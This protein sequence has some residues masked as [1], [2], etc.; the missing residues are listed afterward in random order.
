MKALI[1]AVKSYDFKNDA[2]ESVKGNKVFYITA[3][4]VEG[5]Y[6]QPPMCVNLQDASSISPSSLPGFYDMEFCMKPGKNNK[7]EVSLNSCKFLDGSVITESS[8]GEVYIGSG[9]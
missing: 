4:K 2:G 7:P 6:G 1:L 8:T 3:D 9:V 5:I